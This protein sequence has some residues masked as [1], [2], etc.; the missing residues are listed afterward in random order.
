MSL[1]SKKILP[2]IDD[3]H[4]IADFEYLAQNTFSFKTLYITKLGF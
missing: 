3:V 4:V 2:S 1:H